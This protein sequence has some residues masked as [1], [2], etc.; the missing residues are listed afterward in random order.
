MYFYDIIRRHSHPHSWIFNGPVFLLYVVD[1]VVCMYYRKREVKATYVP[2]GQNYFALFVKSVKD[3]SQIA[4]LWYLQYSG[5]KW[6]RSHPFTAA[7][8]RGGQPWAQ[9]H[10]TEV[11]SA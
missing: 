4:P 9:L 10:Y 8:N 1:K 3:D 11:G 2:L 6:H 5:R 7:Q